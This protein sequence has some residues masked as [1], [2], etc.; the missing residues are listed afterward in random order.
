MN[1]RLTL[2]I[3]P[4]TCENV[5]KEQKWH[6]SCPKSY[7]DGIHFTAKSTGIVMEEIIEGNERSEL[8]T[9]SSLETTSGEVSL[10]FW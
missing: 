9:E 2:N 1:G 10:L 5:V 6:E 3:R 7:D 4:G 8:A